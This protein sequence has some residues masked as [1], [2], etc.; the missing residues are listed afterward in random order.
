MQQAPAKTAAAVTEQPKEE[1]AVA[2]AK[3]EPKEEKKSEVVKE[4]PKP[5]A[6]KQTVK[7]EAPKNEVVKEIPK[8]VEEKQPAVK[9]TA[10]KND[11]VKEVPKATTEK[12]PAVK[13]ALPK[14]QKTAVVNNEAAKKKP[15]AEKNDPKFIN[16]EL[17]NPNIKKD[18]S[19]VKPEAVAVAEIKDTVITKQDVAKENTGKPLMMNSDCKSMATEDD[20][21][22]LRKKL[23]AEESEEEMVNVAKKSFRTKCYTTAQVKNLS[24]LFL[25]DEGKYKFFDSA[26]P[27]VS[28][29]YNFSSLEN[30]LTDAYFINRFKAMIHH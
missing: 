17:P 23:V 22:K 11:I 7:E 13:E 28:D 8:A 10:E 27:F 29:T 18:S 25:K 4:V 15:A 12:Q 2:E 26:Y 3:P 14:T 6:E 16:I 9:E 30:Q 5:T 21:L 19:A 24:V 20:F 1:P